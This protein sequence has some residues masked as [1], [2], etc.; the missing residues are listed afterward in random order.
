MSGPD[1]FILNFTPT[2]MLPTREQSPFVPLSPPEIIADVLA[3]AEIGI[4]SVHLHV[5]NPQ[6]GQPDYR[7]ELYAEVI[8]GIRDDY[9]IYLR[10]YP[11]FPDWNTEMIFV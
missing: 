7:S 5:R 8:N 4:T 10:H 9:R 1:S 3:A 2:G 11:A 6:T